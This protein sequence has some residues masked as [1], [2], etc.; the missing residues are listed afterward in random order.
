M[1]VL[2][3]HGESVAN[4]QNLVR[5]Q[6][7]FDLTPLGREQALEAGTA[8]RD[9][10]FD[11][12]IRSELIRARHTMELLLRRNK[13]ANQTK[14]EE[15]PALSERSEG[16]LEGL[17]F[18]EVRKL[19]PPK[20]YK[21]WKREYF[22]APPGGESMADLADR[23]LPYMRQ[24]VYPLMRGNKT[25]LLVRHEEVMQIIIGDLKQMDEDEVMQWRPENAMPYLFRGEPP[26]LIQ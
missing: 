9:I 3:R 7:D 4:A 17:R 1:L 6:M 12:A 23:I 19:L 20:R 8:I 26:V 2:V 22:E 16:T 14:I 10:Q 11:I 18:D 25:I 24:H 15:S 21:I 5:G 13:F